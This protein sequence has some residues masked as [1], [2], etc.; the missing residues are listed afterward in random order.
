[1]V[2]VLAS[3]TVKAGARDEFISAFKDNLPAVHAEDGCIEYFPAIDMD[4][5]IPVQESSDTMVTICEKW[6]SLAHLQAHLT[7]PHMLSYRERVKDLV[8]NM[9]LKVLTPA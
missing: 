1:M 8:E 7:A 2:I 9:S 4:S 6:E 3:I 5:G